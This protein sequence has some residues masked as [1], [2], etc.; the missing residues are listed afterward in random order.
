M[1]NW[2]EQES[3]IKFESPTSIFVVFPSGFGKTILTKQILTHA[4]GMFT[5]PPSQIFFCYSVYQDLYTEMKKEIPNIHFHQGLPS[6]E[7][8]REWGDMKGHKIV[9]F[10]DLMMDAADSDENSTFDVR[11]FTSLSNHCDPYSIKL[12]SERTSKKEELERK[13]DNKSNTAD[14]ID[15]YAIEDTSDKKSG[16]TCYHCG[17]PFDNY[18]DLF[19]HVSTNYPFN[20]SGGRKDTTAIEDTVSAVKDNKKDSKSNKKRFHF[21]KTALNKTVNKTSIIPYANEKND[22]LQFLANTKQDVDNELT[23][24]RAK[25]RNIKWYVNAKVEMVRDV[26]EVNQD[27]AQ[28]HFR[29]KNYISLSDENNDHNLNEAFQSV[30]RSLEEF[31]T[32]GSNWILNKIVS[33]EIHTVPYSPIAGSSYMKLPTKISGTGIPIMMRPQMYSITYAETRVDENGDIITSEKEKKIAKGIVKC[34][35]KKRLYVMLC[36]NNV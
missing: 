22:L 23:R 3:L 4:N 17:I 36:I 25:K 15:T 24:R 14:Q 27:K 10:D 30:N 2:W 6:K 7:I 5:I 31:I 11:W 26:D 29:N 13:I 35:I 9:V 8:L 19:H 1:D 12:I 28:S 32:K 21:R 34:E 18:D 20:Q 16:L 33:L